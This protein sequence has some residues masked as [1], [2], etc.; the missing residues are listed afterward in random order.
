MSAEATPGF[1]S[2]L[3]RAWARVGRAAGFVLWYAREVS[4]ENGYKHYLD[5]YVA[6]HGCSHGA[7]SEREYWRDKTDRQDREPQARC[8]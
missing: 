1:R 2:L 5:A 3:A 6:R 8:C 4:G 7:M